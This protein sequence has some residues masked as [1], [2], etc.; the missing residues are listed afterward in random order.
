MTNLYFRNF[1]YKFHGHQPRPWGYEVRAD[2]SDLKNNH[3]P[4]CFTFKEKPDEKILIQE[5]ERRLWKLEQKL[6]EPVKEPEP[7]YTETELIEMLVAKGYLAK[8]KELED[9][10]GPDWWT[11][12]KNKVFLRKVL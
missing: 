3:Y 1:Y 10:A 12:L 2:V 6:A 11:W 8:G 7:T 9:L 5:T 4:L